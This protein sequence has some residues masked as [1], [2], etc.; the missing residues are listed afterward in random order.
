MAITSLPCQ[1]SANTGNEKYLTLGGRFQH[2]VINVPLALN[3]DALLG[4]HANT[5]VPKLIGAARMYELT[6]DDSTGR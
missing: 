1:S 2:D 4:K 6:G 3:Q 5:Q